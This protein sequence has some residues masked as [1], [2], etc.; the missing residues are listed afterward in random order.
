MKT[1][2][3]LMPW[4]AYHH[5]ARTH[6]FRGSAAVDNRAK[7]AEARRLGMHCRSAAAAS[8]LQRSR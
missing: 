6:L 5:T 4:L 2:A 7:S 3:P 8:T 1:P